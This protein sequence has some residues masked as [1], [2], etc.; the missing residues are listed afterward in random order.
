[1]LDKGFVDQFLVFD[2]PAGRAINASLI[3]LGNRFRFLVTE[4]EVVKAPQ[5]LPK[6]PVARA[7]WKPDPDLM[8]AA[9]SWLLAGGP[10]HTVYT[11]ALPLEPLQDLAEIAGVE[12]LVID[13]TTTVPNFKK[14]LRW[15]QAYY[16]LAHAT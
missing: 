15:N 3:D 1:M 9:E 11:Q 13:G 12:L 6:L 7:L 2:A 4:V 5:P 14:E 16:R 10:H 8:T